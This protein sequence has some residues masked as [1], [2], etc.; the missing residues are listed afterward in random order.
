MQFGFTCG[1][2]N[3]EMRANAKGPE[4]PVMA[5]TDKPHDAAI[6]VSFGGRADIGQ[7]SDAL[8]NDAHDPERT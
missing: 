3:F 6:T 8:A 2:R 7:R 4:W 1:H 5:L